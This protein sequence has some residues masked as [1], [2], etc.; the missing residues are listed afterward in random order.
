MYGR[1]TFR[2]TGIVSILQIKNGSTPTGSTKVRY[3]WSGRNHAVNDYENPWSVGWEWLIGKGPSHHHFI[4]RYPFSEMLKQH[5]H[6][7]E[8]RNIIAKRIAN[9]LYKLNY[10]YTQ[11]NSGKELNY[12]G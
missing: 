5:E 3:D 1:F 2:K 8:V 11:K 9:S 10:T 6:I 12:R 4:N 7:Q